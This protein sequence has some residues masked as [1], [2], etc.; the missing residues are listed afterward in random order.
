MGYLKVE[1][2]DRE[3]EAKSP[4]SWIEESFDTSAVQHPQPWKKK[5]PHHNLIHLTLTVG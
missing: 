3:G 2:N 1:L 4:L 5:I